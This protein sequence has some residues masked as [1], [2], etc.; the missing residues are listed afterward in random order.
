MVIPR[1]C[2]ETLSGLRLAVIYLIVGLKMVEGSLSPTTRIPLVY[3]S[4]APAVQ[5]S[6]SPVLQECMVITA[7]ATASSNERVFVSMDFR[8][9][10]LFTNRFVWKIENTTLYDDKGPDFSNYELSTIDLQTA[11]DG[12]VQ[13]NLE[14]TGCR[15]LYPSGMRCGRTKIKVFSYTVPVITIDRALVIRTGVRNKFF[16]SILHPDAVY[17]NTSEY[18]ESRFRYWWQLSRVNASN[19]NLTSEGS[20]TFDIPSGLMQPGVYYQASLIANFFPFYGSRN[21]TAS[22][23]FFT[24][25]STPVAVIS[26]GSVQNAKS[27]SALSLWAGES[28]DPDKAAGHVSYSWSCL[29]IET[30]STLVWSTYEAIKGILNLTAQTLTLPGDLL[31]A[32]LRIQCSVV[33]E[34][35]TPMMTRKDTARSVINIDSSTIPIRLFA[36]RYVVP[37]SGVVRVYSHTSYNTSRLTYAWTFQAE[38]STQIFNAGSLSASAISAS[39]MVRHL[40]N[41]ILTVSDTSVDPVLTVVSKV[42][43]L[44]VG[45]PKVDYFKVSPSSGFAHNDTFQFESRYFTNYPPVEVTFGYSSGGETTY[46]KSFGHSDTLKTRLPPGTWTGVVEIRDFIEGEASSYFYPITVLPRPR[47]SYCTTLSKAMSD[48]RSLVSSA[49]VAPWT[50]DQVITLALTSGLDSLSRERQVEC[51]YA[52]TQSL[53]YLGEIP[54]SSGNIRDCPK[55]ESGVYYQAGRESHNVVKYFDVTFSA[56]KY[57]IWTVLERILAKMIQRTSSFHLEPITTFALSTLI[58]LVRGSIGLDIASAQLTSIAKSTTQVLSAARTKSLID[59]SIG[60]RTLTNLI[61]LIGMAFNSTSPSLHPSNPA[62]EAVSKCIKAVE[63]LAQKSSDAQGPGESPIEYKSNYFSTT[64]HRVLI[65]S[66]DFLSVPGSETTV[67]VSAPSNVTAASVTLPEA[68]S[69]LINRIQGDLR[70]CRKAGRRMRYNSSVVSVAYGEDDGATTLDVRL[71]FKG[72]S[73][74]PDICFNNL[75]TTIAEAP[76][77]HS[78]YTC[79]YFDTS[80]LHWSTEGCQISKTIDGALCNFLKFGVW[81]WVGV[82]V[83]VRVRVRVC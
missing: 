3:P 9:S 66:H 62:C 15:E 11:L 13:A 77:C 14:I 79:R 58:Q 33:Y 5:P 36:L 24:K 64:S 1:L 23:E 74:T 67:Y 40:Y 2:P 83:M 39:T 78:W 55:N 27:G 38:G 34:I 26:G 46:L 68:T 45:S 52:I 59:T 18:I 32:G 31:I 28:Y 82:K 10:R 53:N 81:I 4:S 44:I 25:I 71:N 41:F 54:S 69:L 48:M 21:L 8:C 19:P 42:Q 80:S 20:Q 17:F 60:N 70:G 61:S 22:T 72:S 65:D 43:V 47:S 30:G 29:R 57:E 75:Y 35:V 16:A 49:R 6:A 63:Y 73:T 50:Q 51:M 56:M 12:R 76:E 37:Q 7:P